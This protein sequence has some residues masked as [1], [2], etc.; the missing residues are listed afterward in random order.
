VAIGEGTRWTLTSGCTLHWRDWGEEYIVFNDG[1]GDTHLLDPVSAEIL[2]SLERDAHSIESLIS[3]CG[4]VL[5]ADIGRS[6]TA[7]VSDVLR[8]L[9][10]LG[11]IESADREHR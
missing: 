10:A 2:K 4:D 1:P 7:V 5:S 3:R 8:Q 6:P 9:H 11:L